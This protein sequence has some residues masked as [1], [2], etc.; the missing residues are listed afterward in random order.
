M[1]KFFQASIFKSGVFW[2]LFIAFLVSMTIIFVF[3]FFFESYKDLTYRLL[4]AFSIF[5]I[6]LVLVLLYVIF[7]QERTQ[8]MLKERRE[9]KLKEE[10]KHKIIKEKIKDIK[11]RFNEAL[12]ILK[13]STLYKNTRRARYELPWYLMVG[14]ESEGKTTLLEASGLDFPINVNYENRSVKEEGSTKNFQWYYAEHAIFIDMPGNYIHQEQ[15]EN[16]SIV[17][18]KG[19]L[20]LFAK[21]R[22]RRPING[23]VLNIS[24]DT[25]I[26]KSE[27]ELE[28]YGKDLRDR[29]DELSNGFASSIPIYLV[30]TKSDN[31]VGYN[32]YFSTLSEEE[33]EEVLGVTFNDPKQSIDTTVV[34]PELEKLL[35]RVNSS[36]IDKLHHEWDEDSRTKILLFCDE[37]SNIFEKIGMFTDICF[38]QTRYRKSLMLRGIYFT[39]VPQEEEIDTSYL[40][41][42]KKEE[43][44]STGRS[45]RGYFIK[46]L[47]QNVIFPESDLINMDLN[48]KKINKRKQ[49][50]SLS[51]AV[52]SVVLFSFIWIKDF[53]NHNNL[54]HDLENRFEK[55]SIQRDNINTSDNFEDILKTINEI[56]SIKETYEK[57]TSSSFYKL[58][59]FNVEDKTT[60]L[61]NLYQDSLYKLLLPRVAKLLNNQIMSN[62]NNYD[63]TWKN[64][65]TY[66]MLNNE[67][68]R[69][70][71]VLKTSLATSW[72][73]LYPNKPTVQRSL[74]KHFK[75]LLSFGYTPYSLDKNTLKIARAVLTSKGTISITYN[76]L[77]Q[78]VQENM[79][80]KSF[81]FSQ[82]LGS[83]IAS[84]DSDNIKIPGFYTKE[85]YSKVI[86]AQGKALTKEVLLN[87]WVLGARTDLTSSEI[88]DIYSQVL[89]Y[90][91]KDYK[92]YWLSA[93]SSLNIPKKKTVAGLSNQLETLSSGD[94]PILSV[95]SS[96]KIN[97]DIYTPAEVLMK[98]PKVK[99]RLLDKI[100]KIASKNALKKAQTVMSNM[101]VKNVRTF[102]KPYHELLDEENNIGPDIQN[103]M[104][105]LDEV[106]QEMTAIYGGVEP[107][108]DAYR[109]VNGR[110]TGKH[111]PIIKNFTSL[112][113]HVRKWYSQA[114]RNNWNYLLAQAK[115]HINTKYKED[116]MTYYNEKLKNKYPLKRKAYKSSVKVEDFNDFFKINGVLD[117]FFKAY[118]SPFVKLNKITYR[119]FRALELDGSVIGF[120]LEF[121][122]DI[123]RSYR[124]RKALFSSSGKDIGTV[125]YFRPVDLERTLATMQ[126]NYDEESIIYEH[127]PIR[128]T[129]ITWPQ[130]SLS[131]GSSFILY[132]IKHEKVLDS[133]QEGE[134]AL[135]KLIDTFK[136][137]KVTKNSIYFE[138][139]K[140]DIK[141]L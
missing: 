5:F 91:F 86:V 45:S 100:A 71:D 61:Y 123:L 90:Y 38:A 30:I 70:N 136:I 125:A 73:R 98:K 121:M 130:K 132:D 14:K 59:F 41:G 103:A 63:R 47:L 87:N 79:N 128:D 54:L 81:S 49:T 72:A 3:P 139:K 48:Y 126:L 15:D 65:E 33:K 56:D 67:K 112:P 8:Q 1:S 43:K 82:V 106:F 11:T 105:K 115:I 84:F 9:R 60:S 51:L 116:V 36:V 102:F 18:Q 64:T 62:L 76:A 50:I 122:K 69:D 2:T 10:E 37:F 52:A 21:K 134:W 109:V 55:V 131:A 22:S 26:S 85:G 80:L 42:T 141:F 20:K 99:I 113:I 57:E 104:S 107:A 34:R 4:I 24:V 119:R 117:T 68:H 35:K 13:K 39:S 118:I 129:R 111:E 27:K 95:L 88:N 32:E 7:L 135:F 31:I 124:I 19:F 12:K 17:W 94:S 23:I 44:L 127:G 77:K 138:Y 140:I 89:S 78:K 53:V 92:R 28:Q 66:L 120:D 46:N 25:F 110:V 108:Q 40:L 137:K 29:F 83:N 93:I 58:T 101:S 75:Q 97:T 74:N 114:L 16:D 6:T 133:S 96:L